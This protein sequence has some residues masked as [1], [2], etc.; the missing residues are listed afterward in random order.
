M[1]TIGILLLIVGGLGLLASSAMFGDIGIAAAIGSITALLAG[2]GF[3]IASKPV[4]YLKKQ[5]AEEA[6]QGYIAAAAAKKAAEESP[7]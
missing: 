4:N 6:K 7:A 5:F 3:L 2:I 1:K